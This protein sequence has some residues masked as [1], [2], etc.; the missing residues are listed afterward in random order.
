MQHWLDKLIDLTALRGD[1]NVLRDA[2][3]QL[4]LVS[5]QN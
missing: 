3:S 1:E 4:V 5:T 2:L